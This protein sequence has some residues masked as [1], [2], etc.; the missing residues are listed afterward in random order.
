MAGPIDYNKW[1]GTLKFLAG[2]LDGER[3]LSLAE[4][5]AEDYFRVSPE[6]AIYAMIYG[7]NIAL[8]AECML[9]NR[10]IDRKAESVDKILNAD[11]RLTVICAY[12]SGAYDADEVLEEMLSKKQEKISLWKKR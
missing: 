4:A 11:M 2:M 1:N 6:G 5:L 9:E 8:A 12:N 10:S 7:P 3:A